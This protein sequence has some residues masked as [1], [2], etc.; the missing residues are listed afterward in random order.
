MRSVAIH[1][2]KRR[3]AHR[4]PTNNSAT[5][6]ATAPAPAIEA[7]VRPAELCPLNE[8]CWSVLSAGR[9]EAGGMTYSQ[10]LQLVSA[11]EH[12]AMP[13]LCIVTDEVA[14]RRS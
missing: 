4:G 5:A 13:G 2:L 6:V 12:L 7:A 9:V 1:L 11:L 14:A 10:A 8:N 3:A